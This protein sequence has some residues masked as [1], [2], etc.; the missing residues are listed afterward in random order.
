M[1]IGD[2]IKKGDVIA[3]IYGD[4]NYQIDNF[5]SVFKII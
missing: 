2:K 1:T 3:T 5:D 4:D